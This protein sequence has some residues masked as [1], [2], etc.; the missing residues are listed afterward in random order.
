MTIVASKIKIRVVSDGSILVSLVLSVLCITI[1]V[2]GYRQ[3]TVLRSA[4]Q[5][6]IYCENAV[7]ELQNGSDNLTKQ[8]RLAAATGDEQYI[9]AYFEEANV[10]QSREK[11]LQDLESLHVDEDA[12]AALQEALSNS[13]ALMQTEYYSMRLVEE[14]TGS[15]PST[16]PEELQS[17]SL[18]AQDTALSPEERLYKA[19]QLVIGLDYEE[20]KEA[21]SNNVNAAVSV[22]TDEISARQS[23]ADS[24][25][26]RVFFVIIACVF[27]FAVMML[28]VCLLMR[29]WVVSP[30]LKF[31]R[32]I[33]HDTK[34]T[35]GGANELQTLA[36]T[37]NHM[38]DE[39][40]EK[41]RLIKHQA[42]H[43]PLTD[44]LNRGSYD[45]IFDL[46]Q[47]ENRDFA[48]ILIDVDTF[49]SVNDNNGHAVGDEILKKVARL[50]TV[51]FRTID[52][53]CRIGGDEFAII[54][55]EMTSDLNYT[56]TEKIVEINRRLSD[57]DDGMPPV[58]LSVGVAFT[59]R[60]DP[61]KSQFS[62]ADSA[63]YYTKEHGK[64]GCTF[65]PAPK[66]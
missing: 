32:D 43:D 50:L 42:E 57:P 29:F 12:V 7:H 27:V 2:F 6:Y 58:S 8:A 44:L 22:L 26:V 66:D 1:S 65:Y 40:E 39:N 33:E 16:W 63:L 25:F 35:V 60:K 19:Q 56:I 31:N 11:A 20:A 45:R 24:L 55:V 4:M 21:I 18:S 37:Y 41:Q 3:Y 46:Y 54:M 49:K 10:T 62:D 13:I 15:A 47:S 52:Y 14:N 28:L 64:H 36:A 30:L 34:L 5:D 59:D 9:K 17:I 23:R 48:L 61:G 38:F 53:V 51:T